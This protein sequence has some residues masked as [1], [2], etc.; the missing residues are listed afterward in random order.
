ML[1]NF[2]EPTANVLNLWSLKPAFLR[3]HG[4]CQLQFRRSLQ[5]EING[6]A[7]KP[8]SQYWLFLG[9]GLLGLVGHWSDAQQSCSW[10]W[11]GFGRTHLCWNAGAPFR[12]VKGKVEEGVGEVD[13]QRTFYKPP[14]KSS[15]ACVL[16]LVFSKSTIDSLIS[17][18]SMKKKETKS[19]LNQYPV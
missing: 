2:S 19:V 12:W 3:L 18:S 10:G 16:T 15:F 6:L 1:T 8:C 14:G 13:M 5:T 4:N 7:S 11:V 9:G 17:I